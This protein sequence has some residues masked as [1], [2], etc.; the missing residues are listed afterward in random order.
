MA[1]LTLLMYPGME[2][3][4][5]TAATHEDIVQ[6]LSPLARDHGVRIAMNILNALAADIHFK[7]NQAALLNR[8]EPNLKTAC[9]T[10]LADNTDAI[11]RPFHPFQQLIMLHAASRYCSGEV[12]AIPP[13]EAQHRFTRACLQVNDLLLK[14]PPDTRENT[15]LY[16]FSE[17]GPQWDLINNSQPLRSLGRLR[18]LLL[19]MAARG[20]PYGEAAVRLRDR[21]P[22]YLGLPFETVFNLTAFLIF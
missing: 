20:G 6:T 14:H 11:V 3:L 17:L 21:F 16:M 4:T 7:D 19:D 12:D 2:A 8:L 13:E 5:G 22:E 10:F 15:A 1:R 9:A 18:F